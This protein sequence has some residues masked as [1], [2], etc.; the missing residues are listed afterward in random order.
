MEEKLEKKEETIA[1][2][3]H[4]RAAEL[5]Y[6]IDSL[7][8]KEMIRNARQKRVLPEPELSD[9]HLITSVRHTSIGQVKRLFRP[10]D[11]IQGIRDWVGSLSHEPENSCYVFNYQH[12]QYQNW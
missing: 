9:D 12:I 3:N 7:D 6:N 2:E 5:R 1:A 4:E 10:Q 8:H 11:H